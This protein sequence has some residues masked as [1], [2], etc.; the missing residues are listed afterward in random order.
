MKSTAKRGSNTS[1]YKEKYSL[2]NAHLELTA[3]EAEDEFAHTDK[4]GDLIDDAKVKV[5]RK[6]KT[7]NLTIDN[8]G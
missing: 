1:I 4:Y 3:S 2:P 6:K 5:G 7:R 8:N